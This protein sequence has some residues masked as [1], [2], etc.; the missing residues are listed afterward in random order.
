M[1]NHELRHLKV[2]NNAFGHN[3][4]LDSNVSFTERRLNTTFAHLK[5]RKEYPTLGTLANRKYHVVMNPDAYSSNLTTLRQNEAFRKQK[6]AIKDS[7]NTLY[8][9]TKNVRRILLR[10]KRVVLDLVKPV[11]HNLKHSLIKM[12]GKVL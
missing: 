6:K 2:L 10:E 9:K 1:L 11:E 12:F 4:H 3:C 7:I 8:Q 5:D